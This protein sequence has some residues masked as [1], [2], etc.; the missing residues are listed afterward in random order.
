PLIGFHVA[1]TAR[2][3]GPTTRRLVAST[4]LVLLSLLIC[5]GESTEDR[6]FL[7]RLASVSPM[8]LV[9]YMM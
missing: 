5:I 8:L 6:R 7:L 1:S 2:R 9:L 3:S 4:L